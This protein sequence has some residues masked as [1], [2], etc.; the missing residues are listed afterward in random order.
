MRIG[1]DF[2]DVLY[3][4]HHY[5][6]RRIHKRWGLDLSAERITTYYYDLHPVVSKAGISRAELHKEVHAAWYDVDNHIEAALLDPAAPKVL[7]RLGR[8]HDVTIISARTEDALPTLQEF[9][10]RHRIH[11]KRILL[12]KGDK[13]GFDVLVDDYP[14]HAEQNEESGGWSL[15]YHCDENSNYNDSRHPRILRVHDWTEVE[16]FVKRLEE[17]RRTHAT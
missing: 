11:P 7:S 17:E 14:M 9:L 1:V 3:P 5:L 8:R 6:K 12:G 2:D 4:Y 16:A 15:L 10:K 13:R